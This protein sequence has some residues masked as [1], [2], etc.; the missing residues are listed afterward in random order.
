MADY[1]NKLNE[2]KNEVKNAA[3]NIATEEN[4]QKLAQATKTAVKKAKG[5]NKKT[6]AIIAVAVVGIIAVFALFSGRIDKDVKKEAVEAI[7]R[8]TGYEAVDLKLEGKYE[9]PDPMFKIEVDHYISGKYKG[10]GDKEGYYFLCIVSQT[11][12]GIEE[13]LSCRLVEEFES[14]DDLK[15]FVEE[16]EYLE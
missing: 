2:V 6:L 3:N 16:L 10:N 15:D 13:N 11:G 14:K 8:Q 5:L 7:Q 4:K 12:D 9:N 1:K